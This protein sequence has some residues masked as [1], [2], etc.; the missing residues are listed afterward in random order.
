MA[1]IQVPCTAFWY[2]NSLGF[3][4]K[5]PWL[6]FLFCPKLNYSLVSKVTLLFSLCDCLYYSIC[7]DHSLSQLFNISHH[8]SMIISL[9]DDF[10]F[11]LPKSIPFFKIPQFISPHCITSYSCIIAFCTCFPCL[12]LPNFSSLCVNM[13]WVI[14]FILTAPSPSI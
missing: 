7:L 11:L 4:V 10:P 5:W 13:T 14:S 1:L 3:F 8:S 12:P 2:Y 9:E 6:I